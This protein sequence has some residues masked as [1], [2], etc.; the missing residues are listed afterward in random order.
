MDSSPAATRPARL[1][2]L[3]AQPGIIRSLGAHD[4]LTALII[5]QAGF[6]TVFLGGFG[7]SASLLGMPDLNFLGMDEMA[8]QI[9]RVCSRLN[10]P[11]IADGDTGYGDLPQVQRTVRE[12]EAA[13]A[14][15]MILED[16]VAPK[17]CG[18]FEGKRVI[19]AEEMVWKVRA[20]KAAQRDPDFVLIARTDARDTHNLDEAIRRANA[21]GDAG[22][23]VVFIE[24]PHTEGELMR[25]TREVRYP[26]LVN[27]LYGGKTPILPVAELGRL[28]FKI[29]VA[30]IESLLVTAMA[31]RKLVEAFREEGSVVGCRDAMVTFSEIKELLGLDQLLSMRDS[32]ARKS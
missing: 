4:V 32:L 22:A 18:H 26:L 9:R 28:G 29:A 31:V 17:R 14:A 6:E 27:M 19:S 21:C 25:I 20:A 7:A 5:E 24:S 16:Q 8:G 1:R 30:P 23:D 13:G 2:E 15:G 12:F 3:L 10:V 11:V